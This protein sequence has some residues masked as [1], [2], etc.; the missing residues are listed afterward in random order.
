[1][2]ILNLYM[3]WFLPS[4]YP[5]LLSSVV[6]LIICITYMYITST[7]SGLC[8]SSV[9]YSGTTFIYILSWSLFCCLE[10]LWLMYRVLIASTCCFVCRPPFLLIPSYIY[11]LAYMPTANAYLII[12]SLYLILFC[13][14]TI[15]DS[16]LFLL[17]SVFSP[18][19]VRL[20][21]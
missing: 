14:P 10:W 17:I 15:H 7:W 6:F 9:D 21:S 1:M 3:P 11:C 16:Y 19:V 2:L 4:F 5:L 18:I 12:P 8:N 20:M 13:M